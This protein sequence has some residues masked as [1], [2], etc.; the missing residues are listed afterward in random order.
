[1]LEHSLQRQICD[2]LRLEIAPPGKVSRQG[3]VWFAID[4][5]NFAGEVPGLRIGRGIIA[6]I[7][8]TFI[9]WS[10]LAFFVEVKTQDGIL[11][12]AQQ[13]VMAAVLASGGRV[14]VVRDAYETLGCLDAWG[15][16]RA[17]RV[18]QS[19]EKARRLPL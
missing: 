19:A 7:P 18:D 2:M 5:A 1:M 8:D 11:S 17:H 15:I 6:G 12:D 4:H 3:V 16:P 9:L 10:G 14:G 13:S